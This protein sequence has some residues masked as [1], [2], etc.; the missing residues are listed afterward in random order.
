MHTK[1]GQN[2][3][4]FLMNYSWMVLVVML[5][6]IALAK[7]DVISPEKTLP[8]KCIGSAGLDCI[9]KASIS[10]GEGSSAGR[11]LFV[12]MNNNGYNIEINDSAAS[13]FDID[14]KNCGS[15]IGVSANI[16]VD[17]SSSPSG[18]ACLSNHNTITGCTVLDGG[19]AT[20][21]MECE[22]DKPTAGRFK[23]TVTLPYKNINSGLEHTVDFSITGIVS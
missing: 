16:S 13:G 17:A 11:I 5:I 10:Q 19:K 6:L 1:K 20:V 22:A 4:E 8:E 23:G 3:S 7:L 9:S 21:I 15:R 18:L 14:A 12:V 2:I